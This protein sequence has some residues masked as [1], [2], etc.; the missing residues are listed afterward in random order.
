[1]KRPVLMLVILLVCLLASALFWYGVLRAEPTPAPPA[2]SLTQL[3]S[4][5]DN[6]VVSEMGIELSRQIY[7]VDTQPKAGW[8]RLAAPGRALWVLGNCENLLG[9]SGV[10]LKAIHAGLR[11][12][13]DLPT[14]AEVQ[15]ACQDIGLQVAAGRMGEIIELLAAH[16]ELEPA[17][18]RT[19]SRLQSAWLSEIGNPEAH[20]RR[21]AFTRRHLDEMVAP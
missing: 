14:F 4:L 18:S 15:T 3:A 16:P 5:P 6:Q 19:L 13:A 7:H 21:V 10:D 20:R 2:R 1:M 8:R 11:V 17:D 9:Q 12:G